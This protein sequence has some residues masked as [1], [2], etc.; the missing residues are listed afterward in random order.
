ME[1]TQFLKLIL[2]KETWVITKIYKDVF[3]NTF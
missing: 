1:K 3:K 2:L